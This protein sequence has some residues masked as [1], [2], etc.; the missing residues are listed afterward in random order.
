MMYLKSLLPKCLHHPLRKP[1]CLKKIKFRFCFFQSN[2]NRLSCELAVGDCTA[3]SVL[4]DRNIF[5]VTVL[6]HMDETRNM[7]PVLN[8]G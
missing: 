8:P 5:F 4:L 6:T 2:V 7:E 1:T 3:K